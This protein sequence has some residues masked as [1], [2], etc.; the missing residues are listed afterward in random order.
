VTG[1]VGHIVLVGLMG[2]GKSSVGEIVA[3]QL[4]WRFADTDVQ[5][6]Q[7]TG[8][9]VRELWNH[10][11]EAAYRAL[12]RE[13]VLTSLA[14]SE[15]SV[16]AAPGGVIEDE[17]ACEALRRPD[18]RVVYLRAEPPT[19]VERLGGD[20]GHRPLVDDDPAAVLTRQFA[21]RDG[22]YEALA[23]LTVQVDGLEAD[24]VAETILAG[25]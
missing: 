10:D 13:A 18:V 4:G 25:L 17:Q 12:E 5:I 2:V 3:D 19:L 23:D 16:L 20:P 9:T 14:A 21:Q 6:E 15:P 11:G 24:E 22:R 1:G 8:C 7:Q